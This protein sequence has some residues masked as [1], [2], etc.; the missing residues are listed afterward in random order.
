MKWESKKVLKSLSV[1]K[2]EN[3]IESKKGFFHFANESTQLEVCFYS[4]FEGK[5]IMSKAIRP[6]VEENRL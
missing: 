6:P 3:S 1:A 4:I 2:S 5:K